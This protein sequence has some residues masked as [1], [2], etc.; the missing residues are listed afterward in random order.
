MDAF[1]RGV[2]WRNVPE[3]QEYANRVRVDSSRQKTGGKQ[4]FNLRAENNAIGID[5][6][7]QRL[8]AQAIARQQ[9][10]ALA[11]IPDGEGEHA[12][13]L[14]DARVAQLGVKVKDNFRVRGGAERVAAGKQPFAQFG[15]VVAFTVVCDPGSAVGVRHGLAAAV[16]QIENRQARVNQNAV[17]DRYDSV[18]IGPA[19]QVRGG[20]GAG[21][22]YVL[23]RQVSRRDAANPAH[24]VEILSLERQYRA[25]REYYSGV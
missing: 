7:V 17:V 24:V 14:F 18:A 6:V 13:H 16:A 21:R 8:D 4:R 2:G 23:R 5:C 1:D 15:G 11:A 22:G 12:A 19:M 9:E 10:A 25:I 20:H 3:L